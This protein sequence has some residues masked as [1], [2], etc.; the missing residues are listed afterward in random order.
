[1]LLITLFSCS[2]TDKKNSGDRF[3]KLDSE[4]LGINFVN[5]LTETDSL[6]YFTY[7]YIYMGGGVA[8]GDIN[9]DGVSRCVFY[10]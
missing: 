10:W 4:T 1:M 6:N 2:K 9:N 8:V 3:E 5:T 7:P